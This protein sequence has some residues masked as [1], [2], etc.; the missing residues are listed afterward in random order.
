ML[1]NSYGLF[2]SVL[3][4]TAC[5]GSA[6]VAGNTTASGIP[7]Y[8]LNSIPAGNGLVFIG[9]AGKRSNPKET[10]QLALEDAARRIALFHMVSGEYAIENNIGSGAFDYVNNTYTSLSYDE[11]RLKLYVDALQYNADTDIIEIENTL[12]VRAVYPLTLSVPVKYRP[13]YGIVD[14]KPSWVD[15]SSLEIEGYEVSVGYSGRYSSLTDTLKHSY[16]NAIFAIIRNINTTSKNSDMLYQNTGNLFGY[17]TA[18]DN[19]TYS[20]GALNG[21]YILDTWFDPKTKSVWTLAIA[22]KAE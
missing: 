18:S 15:N 21:F 22:G 7:L 8:F 12:I 13:S 1:K 6:P 17:K 16:Q 9:A 5:A 14:Q 10:L 2:I 4:C 19:V 20:Y 3:L 11:E